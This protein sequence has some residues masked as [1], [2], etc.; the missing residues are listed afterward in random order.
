MRVVVKILE[1]EE[2]TAYDQVT[3]VPSPIVNVSFRLHS[4][5]RNTALHICPLKETHLRQ[6]AHQQL[7]QMVGQWCLV[8]LSFM[9]GDRGDIVWFFQ[10][11]EQGG[12]NPQ[13]F[14][15]G[16]DV[17]SSLPADTAA[18]FD[19]PHDFPSASATDSNPPPLVEKARKFGVA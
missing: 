11:A 7:R 10:P 1:L 16:N 19:A 2:G 13:L 5:R 18:T 8:N 15:P 9:K 3:K 4:E 6:G 12:V 14:N 17:A